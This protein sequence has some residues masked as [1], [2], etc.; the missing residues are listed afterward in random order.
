MTNREFKHKDEKF[1][2]ACT[3]AKIMPTTRQA[4]KWRR[5]TGLAYKKKD[6]KE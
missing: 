6:E 1:Q 2:W 5:K 3:K 4:S